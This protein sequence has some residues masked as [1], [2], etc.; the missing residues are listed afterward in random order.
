MPPNPSAETP[1]APIYVVL[2]LFEGP[3]TQGMFPYVITEG[4]LPTIKHLAHKIN[5][6]ME[7]LQ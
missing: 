5:I 1:T 2:P 7:V 3:F 6:E 4:T